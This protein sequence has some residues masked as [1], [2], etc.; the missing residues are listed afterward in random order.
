MING[1]RQEWLNIALRAQS[2]A[3][4]NPRGYTI[5]EMRVLVDQSGKPVFWDEPMATK[6]EPHRGAAAFLEKI[7]ASFGGR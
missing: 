3:E 6:L 2:V 1:I 4:C 7:L 5:V